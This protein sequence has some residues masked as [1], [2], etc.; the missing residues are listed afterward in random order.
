[1]LKLNKK[2]CFGL[3]GILVLASFLFLAPKT[4]AAVGANVLQVKTADSPVV[5]FL[6]HKNHLKKAYVNESSY[7]NYGNRWS[8]IKIVTAAELASWPEVKLIKTASAPTIY[9]VKDKQKSVISNVDDLKDYN[10]FGEPIISVSVV[11][12]AQYELVSNGAIGLKPAS[13]LLVFNDLVTNTSNNTYLTNTIG[14]LLGI[15]RFRSP[16]ETA[17]ITSLTFKIRGLYNQT[18]LDKGFVQDGNNVNYEANVNVDKNND[19]IVVTF[20]KPLELTPSVEKVVKVYLNLK[21]CSCENQTIRIELQKATDIN[22]SLAPTASWPLQGTTFNLVNSSNLLASVKIE[23]LSLATSTLIVSPSNRLI[24]KFK[25]TE[26]SGRDDAIVK[27]IVLKNSGSATGNDWEDFRLFKGEQIISRV[28]TLNDDRQI[29]FNLSYLRVGTST[30]A[31]L[32]VMASLKTGYSKE[33]TL[34]LS[35][36]ELSATGK[37]QTFSLAPTIVNIEES[38]PLD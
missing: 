14:N 22:S 5:Y 26:T 6:N 2:Y 28:S 23:E 15:F 27:K 17:T 29:V 32:K 9:Y 37:T 18:I 1:M 38:F 21:S 33:A 13:S 30:P 20:S 10:L 34:N 16:V 3:A 35:V 12:L 24:A 7:L 31:E 36:R 25:V 11:D 19:Q 4:R 8:D